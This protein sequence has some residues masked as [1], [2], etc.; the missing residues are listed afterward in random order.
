MYYDRKSFF[1]NISHY[2]SSKDRALALCSL[3]A[4]HSHHSSPPA[5]Y[6]IIDKWILRWSSE[7]WEWEKHEEPFDGSLQGNSSGDVELE[8]L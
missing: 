3:R 5:A 1:P 4:P 7:I 8:V 2:S 6:K